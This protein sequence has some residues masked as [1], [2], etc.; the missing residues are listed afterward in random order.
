MIAYLTA[1]ILAAP[2][3]AQRAD[4]DLC[5]AMDDLRAAASFT[6]QAQ[7]VF[8][9]KAAPMESGCGRTEDTQVQRAFCQAAINA[10]G[11]EFTHKFPWAIY[12]CLRSRGRLP[13]LETTAQYTGLVHRRRITHLTSRLAGGGRIDIRYVPTG[14][15]SDEPEFRG[16]W[17]RYD[18]VIS[19]PS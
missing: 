4:P 13:T 2:A 15:F 1:A 18:L 16:Y 9:I 19:P 17:G 8:V 5:R 6:H 10:I 12:D 7:H 3:H 14:D 11:V